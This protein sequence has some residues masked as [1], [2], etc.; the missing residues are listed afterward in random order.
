MKSRTA[1]QRFSQRVAAFKIGVEAEA[2]RVGHVEVDR[3]SC[4]VEFAERG[5]SCPPPRE[6][7][8]GSS[9]DARAS[10]RKCASRPRRALRSAAGCGCA[11]YR[12]PTAAAPR[13]RAGSAAARRPAP[14][15]AER[16]SKSSRPFVSVAKKPLSHGA[17]ADI[18]GA[19]KEDVFAL[20]HFVRETM[21]GKARVGKSTRAT[22]ALEVRCRAANFGSLELAVLIDKKIEQLY[23][24]ALLLSGDASAAE[25]ALLAVC[26]ESAH[27]R[28]CLPNRGQ[29]NR[30]SHLKTPRPLREKLRHLTDPCGKSSVALNFTRCRSRAAA[31]W[32]CFTSAFLAASEIAA[33]LNFT[34]EELSDA[35]GDARDRLL[36]A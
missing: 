18:S 34:L 19:D 26:S 1:G 8:S 15:P 23:R 25:R 6:N 24:F 7:T 21:H 4:C 31:R 32:R 36:A 22:S 11:K 14:T 28:G 3:A 12:R 2:D 27:A 17:A 9:R 30:L 13:R 29:R 5:R 16:I 35:L 10:S 33:M 20:G